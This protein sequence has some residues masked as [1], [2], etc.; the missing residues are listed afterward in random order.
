VS[1]HQTFDAVGVPGESGSTPAGGAL[2]QAQAPEERDYERRLR[3][4]V[5]HRR[6]L[7]E[8]TAELALLKGA[9]GRFEAVCSARVGSLLA[10]LRR[11]DQATAD[12]RGRIE[13]LRNPAAPD[14]E[15]ADEDPEE[16]PGDGEG[17][18]AESFARLGGNPWSGPNG[19]PARERRGEAV[20][21]TGDEAEAKRLYRDLARRCHPDFARGDAER[22]QREAMMQ[23][24]NEAYRARDLEE[25][26]ALRR[27]TEADAPGFAE[28]PVGERLAW[29]AA[30]LERVDALLHGIKAEFA[31]LRGYE[32]HRLWRRYEAG[33]PVLDELEDDLE[34][35]LRA[36]NRRL[37][38]L[39]ASY[40]QARGESPRRRSRAR[41]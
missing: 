33:E 6:R 12:Y 40:L 18:E 31:R 2:V 21:G 17:A 10:E 26:R 25:L 5:A 13:R 30:E 3:L 4:L 41:A 8:L 29:L 37:D 39:I 38:A 15:D 24:V 14:P 23:R 34:G 7:T 27:E 35:R 9:L 28:R 32:L 20:E 19:D 36:K 11:V 22:E 16:G 1:H